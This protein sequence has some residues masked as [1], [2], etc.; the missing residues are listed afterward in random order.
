MG[1]FSWLF[2]R[3]KK[4]EEIP[5]LDPEPVKENDTV[6][7]VKPKRAKYQ[8]VPRTYETNEYIKSIL[9]KAQNPDLKPK[10]HID[11][12][13]VKLAKQFVEKIQGKVSEGNPKKKIL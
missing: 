8:S 5:K 2:G 6:I 1:F 13:D 11:T 12:S 4:Q 10:T 3:K 7:E 9:K